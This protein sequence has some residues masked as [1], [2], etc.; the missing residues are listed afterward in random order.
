MCSEAENQHG[1][2]CVLILRSVF[3]FKIKPFYFLFLIG[4]LQVT[5]NRC[6]IAIVN[7]YSI[8]SET[9]LMGAEKPKPENETIFIKMFY[10]LTI[11]GDTRICLTAAASG[12]R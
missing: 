9:N 3:I 6:S 1:C 5:L 4:S 2:V 10:I 7:S 8:Q 12:Q 11:S